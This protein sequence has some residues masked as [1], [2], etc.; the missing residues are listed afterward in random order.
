MEMANT[1]G[2]I[3]PR[4]VIP[5]CAEDLSPAIAHGHDSDLW[6]EVTDKKGKTI[7]RPKPA[8]NEI[9]AKLIANV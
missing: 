8:A 6:E 4:R 2:P 1:I 5:T 9:A 3:W 7:C